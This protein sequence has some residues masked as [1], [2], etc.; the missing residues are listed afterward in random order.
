MKEKLTE[1]RQSAEVG[2]F[3]PMCDYAVNA[4]KEASG[5]I[6]TEI[7]KI[8][9]QTNMEGEEVEDGMEIPEAGKEVEMEGGDEAGESQS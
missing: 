8:K 3:K 6:D 2:E 1:S 4:F 5:S 7:E 9:G